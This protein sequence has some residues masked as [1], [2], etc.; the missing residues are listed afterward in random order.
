MKRDF[1][2]FRAQL[3][4]VGATFLL[5]LWGVLTIASS[6]STSPQPL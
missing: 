5:G 1:P 3:L 2:E 6:Q 4:A